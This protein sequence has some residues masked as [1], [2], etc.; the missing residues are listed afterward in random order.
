[1]EANPGRKIIVV[2]SLGASLGQGL[3]VHKA[4]G[5]KNSGKTIDEVHNWVEENKLNVCH[6]FTVDDLV[7][8]FR[9]GRVSKTSAFAAGVLNIKPVLHIDNEGHLVPLSKVRGRKKSLK[10]LADIMENRMLPGEEDVFI[11]HSDCI[12]DAELLA[13]NIKERFGI[14]VLIINHIGP[15]IGAHTGPGTISLFFMGRER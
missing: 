1:M 14:E 12:E 10:E 13:K 15:T 7:Y 5:L 9:G 11:S 6:Y 2:D 8:L 4:I 3:L